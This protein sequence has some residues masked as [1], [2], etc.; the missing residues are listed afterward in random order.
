MFLTLNFNFKKLLLLY[1]VV[2]TVY[3]VPKCEEPS[4]ITSEESFGIS[5]YQP[6]T[7]IEL[8]DSIGLDNCCD[9]I[10]ILNKKIKI[11]KNNK[12]NLITDVQ[13]CS[14]Q[15]SHS[16]NPIKNTEIEDTVLNNE[17]VI[18]E[19]TTC[20]S[21]H[22]DIKPKYNRYI[23][24]SKVKKNRIILFVIIGSVIVITFVIILV[25]FKWGLLWESVEKEVKHRPTMYNNSQS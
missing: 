2:V 19:E 1:T 3:I 24:M 15:I 23:D 12:K 9:E 4:C 10:H 8:T 16:T 20:F 21:L 6:T 7:S 18:E 17:E 5:F 11:K 13:I 14:C 22:N 25:V